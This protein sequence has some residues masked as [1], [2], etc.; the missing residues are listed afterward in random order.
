M[1]SSFPKKEN[2]SYEWVLIDA[3]GKVLG[4]LASRISQILRGKDRVGYSPHLPGEYGVIVINVEQIRLS[5]KKTNQKLY[6]HHSGYPGGLKTENY[7]DR[8]KRRP[9][10]PL[11]KAVQGM[12]PKNRLSRMLLSRLRVYSGAEH[13]HEAQKPKEILSS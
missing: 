2:L 3:K 1:Q 11:R 9:D 12:L 10:F 4:R 5:G 13:P 7:S 6:H 8:L